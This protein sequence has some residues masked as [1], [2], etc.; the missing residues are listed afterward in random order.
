MRMADDFAMETILSG[1]GITG[2]DGV[3]DRTARLLA[4]TD[5]MDGARGVIGAMLTPGV[6]TDVRD[7]GVRKEVGVEG[8]AAAPAW[9]DP[10]SNGALLASRRKQAGALALGE[11]ASAPGACSPAA[12]GAGVGCARGSELPPFCGWG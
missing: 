8:V 7:A 12:A 3:R 2:E 1:L 10:A 6:V 11:R 4:R 5:E 9:V